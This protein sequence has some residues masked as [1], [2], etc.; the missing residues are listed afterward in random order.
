[1]VTSAPCDDLARELQDLD[2]RTD[3]FVDPWAERTEALVEMVG[4]ATDAKCDDLVRVLT[5]EAQLAYAYTSHAAILDSDS[6]R[7]VEFHPELLQEEAL[8]YL[9]TRTTVPSVYVRA[10]VGD[11]LWEHGGPA[12]RRHGAGAGADYIEVSAIAA[13]RAPDREFGWLQVGDSLVRG[14]RLA[15]ASN[16]RVVLRQAAEAALTFLR[17]FDAERMC[18]WTMDA[19]VAL[20]EAAEVLTDEERA[21][22]EGTLARTA[23]RFSEGNEAG[24]IHLAQASCELQKRFARACGRPPE[25][26]REIELALIRSFI[27]EGDRRESEG[28][29][30]IASVAYTDAV[31][32]IE[33][34]GGE[35]SLLNDT[36]AQLRKSRLA[37]IDQMT[38]VA[39]IPIEINKEQLEPL[40]SGVSEAPAPECLQMLALHPTLRLSRSEV[41]ASVVSTAAIAPLSSMFS[42]VTLRG[43]GQAL[44]PSD[45]DEAARLKLYQQGTMMLRI[46]EGLLL[47]EILT[48]LI[49]RDDLGAE[50]VLAHLTSRGAVAED[51]LPVVEVGIRRLWDG[52]WVSAIH[53]LVPQL[54]DVIRNLMRRLGRDPM[55]PHRM[56][57]GISLEAPLGVIL[58]ELS[59]AG[60][61]DDLLFMMQLVFDL[62]GYDL[63]NQTAHGLIR[64]GDCTQDNAVRVLQ[65]YLM[66]CEVSLAQPHAEATAG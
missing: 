60:V 20:I 59:S 37:G 44:A 2:L 36:R 1:M 22:V 17:K 43:G 9:A 61:P 48:R 28:E 12:R 14:A 47:N 31:R 56:I 46:Q 65:L 39:S 38:V 52:D 64:M 23:T 35:P 57:E 13:E 45:P 49:A 66:V 50:A 25:H 29:G 30:L 54:E 58:S 21:E 6:S 40:I 10:K 42:H 53:I 41:Q 5:W 63:R 34:L 32:L 55:R 33:R 62:F 26:L 16:N 11:F 3:Q 27:E 4:R 8:D 24:D 7:F 19:G 18:R 15:R 51:N